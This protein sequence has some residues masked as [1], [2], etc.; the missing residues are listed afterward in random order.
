MANLVQNANQFAMT[1]MLG[2]LTRDPQPATYPCMIDP[3]YAASTV[4][5]AA[6]AVK[7]VSAVGPQII[8]Q[9]CIGNTDGPVFGVII[10]N[11]QKARYVAG[12]F[13]EIAAAGDVILLKSSA[14]INRGAQVS[15]VNP[16]VYTNDPQVTT[17]VTATHYIV[18]TALAT[19][20]AAN[21]LVPILV[22]PALLP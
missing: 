15:C 13:C 2:A 1:A 3:A 21:L 16:T 22:A 7:L 12:E 10:Y 19:V 20:G 5:T 9:P 11:P 4:I 14:A 17:D 18:G 6:T 8:V